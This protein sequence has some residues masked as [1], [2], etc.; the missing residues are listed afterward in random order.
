M[1]A[2]TPFILFGILVVL[3]IYLGGEACDVAAKAR[4]QS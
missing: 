2:A 4:K 3:A 1:A